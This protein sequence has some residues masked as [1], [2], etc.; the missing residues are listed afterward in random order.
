M[1]K[2][3]GGS[4]NFHWL[5]IPTHQ[6]VFLIITSLSNGTFP[7]FSFLDSQGVVGESNSQIFGQVAMNYF[8]LEFM[9]ISAALGDFD[10]PG[11]L[12]Q[13]YI[14]F[15]SPPTTVIFVVSACCLIVVTVLLVL[16]CVVC[17][18]RSRQLERKS[19]KS[20]AKV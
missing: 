20:K 19:T 9:G 16:C 7:T 8:M 12:C 10:A 2:F 17:I 6:D 3:V 11:N 5:N 1:Q 13:E 4:G 18:L 14:I 15:G